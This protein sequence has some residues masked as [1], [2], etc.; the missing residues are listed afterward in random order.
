MGDLKGKVILEYGCSVGSLTRKL[1]PLVTET[2]R[3]FAT[4]LSL[5]KVQVADKRT[6][7]IN[8]VSVHHHPHLDD[9]KLGLPQQ[10]DGVISIGM[11]SYMQNPTKI[12][13]SLA[14]HVKM[15][16]E[17]IF[18]DYDKFFYLIP[19][20]DWIQNDQQLTDIFRKAGFAVQVERKRGLLWQYIVISG[21]KV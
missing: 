2:G 17:I 12:L 15:D 13:W 7:Q 6:N 10:V 3:I 11:L 16:G 9:F 19:N 1:A 20:V 18:V 5:K 14:K 8:H 4:D 21:K